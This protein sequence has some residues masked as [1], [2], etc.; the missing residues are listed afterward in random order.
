MSVGITSLDV[1]EE[2]YIFLKLFTLGL[3]KLKGKNGLLK[4]VWAP[5]FLIKKHENVWR[6][7]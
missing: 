2:N 4:V 5:N 6:E 1:F 3:T 7:S